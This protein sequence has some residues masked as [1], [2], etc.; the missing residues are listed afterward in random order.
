MA[1]F[2]HA[3]AFWSSVA[4][5][6]KTDQAV[7]FDLYNEPHGI[8][9]HCWRDG[10]VL[11]AGWRAA[12]MQTLVDAV[13]SAGAGQPIIATGL[14]WGNNLSSWLQY[15][16]RDPA[17][18]L[19]AGF[20]VYNNLSCA[21]DSCWNKEVRPV[22]RSVPVVAAEVGDKECSGAFIRSFLNWA[23]SAG[24]SY[25]GWSWNPTG[26]AGP[27]LIRSW[28]G[29]PTRDGEALRTHLRRLGGE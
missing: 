20:H 26:C 14:D 22:A 18:Q 27:A 12:G 15:R 29:Q 11:P 10:C 21:V 17:G 24:V 16:P 9:W 6:F 3:P 13:R 28:D 5:A 25:L 2:D 7:I 1:D 19:V 8:G 23:D 4:R